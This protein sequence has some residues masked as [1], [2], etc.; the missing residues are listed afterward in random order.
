MWVC[1][2]TLPSPLPLQ[3]LLLPH[4]GAYWQGRVPGSDLKLRAALL[5]PRVP[6]LYQ[7]ED[8]DGQGET[9]LAQIIHRFC[10]A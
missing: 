5:V 3:L 7:N 10:N 6:S 1:S 2:K 4:E 9:L 8:M